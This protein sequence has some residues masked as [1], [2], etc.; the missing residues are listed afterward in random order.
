MK[1]RL[2]M[3]LL[4]LVAGA[5]VNVAVAWAFAA[6]RAWFSANIVNAGAKT[7]DGSRVVFFLQT[8]GLTLIRHLETTDL[9]AGIR[10]MLDSS[11]DLME[12]KTSRERVPPRGSMKW[13][14]I[15]DGDSRETLKDDVDPIT[16]M[17]SGWPAH[18]LTCWYTMPE[19]VS[20]RRLHGGMSIGEAGAARERIIP[21]RPIASGFAI[22]TV[23]YAAILW[24]LFAAP[25]ALWGV[26]RRRRIKRGLCPKCAYPVGTNERCTECGASL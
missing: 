3:I 20:D 8:R 5:I 6:D 23:F 2:L 11:R 14:S 26:R 13:S 17:A 1:R 25:F 18:S 4:L 15:Y 9:A 24:L 22:N 12:Y 19:A 16:E 7:T 21:L 10:R